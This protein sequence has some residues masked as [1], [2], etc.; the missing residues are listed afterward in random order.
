MEKV[1]TWLFYELGGVS[2]GNNLYE[3]MADKDTPENDRI[4]RVSKD[5]GGGLLCVRC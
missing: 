1:D 4:F 3:I 5:G 2:L